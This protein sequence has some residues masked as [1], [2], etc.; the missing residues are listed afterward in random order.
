MDNF[1]A[2]DDVTL[3]FRV[4]STRGRSIKEAVVNALARRRYAKPY[5]EVTALRN[6][7]LHIDNGQRVGIVGDNGAGKSSMLKVISRIYPPTSGRVRRHGFLVPLLEV[8]IGFNGEL[9][10][11]ENIYLTGAIMG[12]SRRDMARKVGPILDFSEL[13]EFA[14]TPVKYFSSGMQQRLAF[15]VA[16]EIDPEILLL[17][18]VFSVG[19]IH[20]VEKARQRMRALID[21]S[22]ILVLV[23]H[24]MELIEEYCNRCVWIRG[25]QMAVDGDPAEVVPAYRDSVA[26]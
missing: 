3:A 20:W 5:T 19:D 26:V 10:G 1:I 6:V 21:R 23:S 13:H 25:G 7:T 4:Y 12:F 8:G 24:Q 14:D 11:R 17:D 2:L 22:R 16:T 15:S 18:E 9:S